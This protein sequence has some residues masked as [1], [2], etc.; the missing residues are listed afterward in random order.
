MVTVT[1]WLKFDFSCWSSRNIKC[2]S[3]HLLLSDWP[4]ML[5]GCVWT[6]IKTCGNNALNNASDSLSGFR[7]V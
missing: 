1:E 7:T 6:Y 4:W 2:D 3:F 5:Q